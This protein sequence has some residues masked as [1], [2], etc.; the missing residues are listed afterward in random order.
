[1]PCKRVHFLGSCVCAQDRHSVPNVDPG[2][3]A[4]TVMISCGAC[5]A[6]NHFSALHILAL[7]LSRLVVGESSDWGASAV[8]NVAKK[9]CAMSYQCLSH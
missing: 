1:M 2:V 4:P 8:V 7:L 3:P 6:I 5:A 9:T